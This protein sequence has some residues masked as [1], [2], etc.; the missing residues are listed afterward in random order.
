M[1]ELQQLTKTYQVQGQAIHAL[2]DVN[3]TVNK[4][5]IVGVVG[6]SGA[7]K[8]TLLRCVNLLERPD[9]GHVLVDNIDLTTLSTSELRKQRHKIGMIFQ[10]FNLLESRTA[11]QNIALPL[12]LLG[13]SKQA[14]Q[15]RVT[16]L[17]ELVDLQDRKDHYPHELSG[18]QKQRVAIARALATEPTVL[19]CDEATSSLDP[20]STDS[21][22]QLLQQINRKMNLTILLITH[23]LEVVKQICTR[24]GVLELGNLIEVGPTLDIFLDPQHA[25]TKQLV[26]KALHLDEEQDFSDSTKKLKPGEKLL[27]IRL[28]FVGKESDVPLITHLVKEFDVTLNISH[29]NL[30]QVQNTTIGFTV[31]QLSGAKAAVDKA[32]K[33]IEQSQVKVE[34]LNHA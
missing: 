28:T 32:F 6:K 27:N 18:G 2:R 4:G 7:G 17:L 24:T 9:S 15:A 22:L 29:A 19:L 11:F 5:E 3:L 21:V 8:S 23:E 20:E 33:Y 34:V 30:E 12:E 1:I 16:D 13:E 10:H 31:C 26:Q 14:I 25:T